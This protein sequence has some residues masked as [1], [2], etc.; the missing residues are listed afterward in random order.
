V[1][2]V[3]NPKFKNLK[4]LKVLKNL[5]TKQAMKNKREHDTS[6]TTHVNIRGTH[7]TTAE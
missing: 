2:S 7:V 1:Q 4:F 3:F 6:S 5:R